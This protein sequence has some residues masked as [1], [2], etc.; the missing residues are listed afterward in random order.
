MKISRAKLVTI[1]KKCV[2]IESTM[3]SLEGKADK[4]S[5]DEFN[6]LVSYS[7]GLHD[8]AIMCGFT[9][10]EFLAMVPYMSE[11]CAQ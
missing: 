11:W 8:M 10:E 6:R 3:K 2:D 5:F 7:Q 1:I 9:Q 4:K